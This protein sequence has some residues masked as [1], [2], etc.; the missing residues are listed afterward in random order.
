MAQITEFRIEVAHDH[1]DRAMR[2]RG[3]IEID[4]AAVR[5]EDAPLEAIRSVFAEAKTS[6]TT[7]DGED[8]RGMRELSHAIAGKA[9]QLGGKLSAVIS[10]TYGQMVLCEELLARLARKPAPVPVPAPLAAAA[11][12]AAQD[13]KLLS[14]LNFILRECRIMRG[15][16][17]ALGSHRERP[18]VV[19]A[20]T[21]GLDGIRGR[22][23]A[24]MAE[25]WGEEVIDGDEKKPA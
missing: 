2:V 23:L 5:L 17:P 6:L 18:R 21:R 19:D 15:D 1:E 7:L 16:L 8:N 13:R 3:V 12:M 10:K 25:L 11:E 14:L 20:L 24:L 9:P 4:G 22:L